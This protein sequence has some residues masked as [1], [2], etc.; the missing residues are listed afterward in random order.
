MR[1]NER[2]S[3]PQWYPGHMAKA[4]RMLKENLKLVDLVI[5]VLD[6]RIPASSRNPD[7]E[8]L[9]RQKMRLL[10]LSKSDLAAAAQ[11]QAWIRKFSGEGHLAVPFNA[12]APR[13]AG[14]LLDA[15]QEIMRPALE[16]FAARGVKK[17]VRAIVAG[18]PNAGKSSLINRMACGNPA[19]VGNKPGVTRGKQWVKVSPYLELLDTPGLLW[20]KLD[21]R[22]VA[23]NIAYVG[24]IRDEI[25]DIEA[26]SA[27]LLDKLYVIAPDS[28]AGVYGEKGTM[29]GEI[30]LYEL[31]RRRNWM[32]KPGV[33]DTERMARAVIDDFRTGKLGRITLESPD[34]EVL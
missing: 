19:A 18:I 8:E 10:V 14:H 11:T 34:G 2:H 12:R 3:A 16:R 25:M 29:D 32:Q 27:G 31:C 22:Q 26:L 15:V 33:E 30:F 24:S 6:A 7:F 20:P 28:M 1:E 4:R 17:T 13:D 9:F 23:M 21:N 5:E